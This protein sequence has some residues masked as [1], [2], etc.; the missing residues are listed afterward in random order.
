MSDNPRAD[1]PDVLIG[2]Y[3]PSTPAPAERGIAGG[4][5]SPVPPPTSPPPTDPVPGSDQDAATSTITND[6]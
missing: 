1:E 3:G 2:G 5:T 6:T 4:E